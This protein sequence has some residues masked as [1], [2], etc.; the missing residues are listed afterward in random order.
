MASAE[1]LIDQPTLHKM[2]HLFLILTEELN[3]KLEFDD[4]L[5]QDLVN[6]SSEMH[7]MKNYDSSNIPCNR[8]KHSFKLIE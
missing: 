1:S 7:T 3:Y 8:I 4:D 6:L 5:Y 2:S